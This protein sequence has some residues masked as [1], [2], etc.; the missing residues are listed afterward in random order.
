MQ[1][2]EKE[3]GRPSD[4]L[5]SGEGVLWHGDGTEKGAVRETST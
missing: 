3:P 5:A 1:L 2:E 4:V